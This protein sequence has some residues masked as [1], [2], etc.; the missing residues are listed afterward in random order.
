LVRIC[1]VRQRQVTDPTV[2]KAFQFL[3]E[4]EGGQLRSRDNHWGQPRATLTGAA[5]V[6][7]WLEAQTSCTE[8]VGISGAIGVPAA[9][10]A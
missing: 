5:E 6:V 1:H 3:W 8:L 9:G 10:G 7:A 2:Q 4:P